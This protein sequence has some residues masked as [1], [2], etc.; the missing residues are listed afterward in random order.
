MHY[1]RLLRPPKVTREAGLHLQ[2]LF[3][4]TT[5]L[6]DSFLQPDVPL[7]LQITAEITESSNPITINLAKKGQIIWQS[8]M[9]VAKPKIAIPRPLQAA[10]ASGSKMNICILARKEMSADGGHNI[11]SHGEKSQGQGQIMPVWAALSSSNQGVDVSTRRI[12]LDDAGPAKYIVQVEEEIGESIARHIWDAGVLAMC[13]I[14]GAYLCPNLECSQQTLPRAIRAALSSRVSV[15]ILELGCGVGILGIGLA[16]IFPEMRKDG[17]EKCTIMMTDLD[18][19]EERARSNMQRIATS[20]SS[21]D[22][23]LLY[24]NLDWEHGRNGRFGHEVASRYWDLIIISDCTYNV[25]M[26]PALV[27]TLNA[28]ESS[29]RA[30]QKSGATETKVFL[31]TKPRHASERAFF[32]LMADSQWCVQDSQILGL[33]VL[34]HEEESIELYLFQKRQVPGT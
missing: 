5:D 3:T 9:R 23:S 7:D 11:L 27:E 10:L 1:I 31:A 24:E 26:L 19:A 2:L 33:P 18:E 25:D 12:L 14:A 28:I 6:G 8:G 16:T 20:I 13:S 30:K 29:S 17:L 15:S 22:M 34:G 32:D 4:I 21:R